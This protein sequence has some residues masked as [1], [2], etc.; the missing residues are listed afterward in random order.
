M[1]KLIGI[2]VLGRFADRRVTMN[3]L[4]SLCA[5]SAL[6]IPSMALAQYGDETPPPP[7][8]GLGATVSATGTA[9]GT[10]D[11]DTAAD[12]LPPEQNLEEP[13][14]EV[15][16]LDD[17][18]GA[19]GFSHRTFV[20]AYYMFNTNLPDDAVRAT[21]YRFADYHGFGLT[22]AGLDLAYNAEQVG[23]TIS[24]RYGAGANDLTGFG[25]N[26]DGPDETPNL[27][28]AYVS[29]MPASSFTLDV[30]QFGTIYGAE[31]A[32]SWQNLNYTRGAVFYTLQP[33]YHLGARAAVA[34]SD[35]LGLSFLVTNGQGAK[36]HDG[37]EVPS[38]GAQLAVTPSDDMSLFVGYFTG[39]NAPDDNGDW[40]HLIDVVFTMTSGDF[41][42]VGNFDFNYFA[43]ADNF[44]MGISLAAGLKFTEMLE[45]ALRGEFLYGALGQGV[46]PM[47]G[48]PLDQDDETLITGTLTIRVM[49][50]EQLAFTV[51]ARIDIAGEDVYPAN[52]TDGATGA[53]EVSSTTFALVVGATAHFE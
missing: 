28:Q 39:A 44:N 10:T 37:N 14:G 52:G 2:K 27:A 26:L 17:E 4:L 34:L 16:P 41:S 7:D 49:P 47:T 8:E 6:L 48:L 32:E 51:D 18:A 40:D 21:S 31:V 46:D 20:D 53:A 25:V 33:F 45:M 30:G 36:R 3:K 5:A 43:V 42:L 38:L 23:A 13:T 19:T 11:T 50:V 22:F 1:R 12:P 29:W 9:T 24:V 35:S 15:S